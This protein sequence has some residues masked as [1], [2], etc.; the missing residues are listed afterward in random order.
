ATRLPLSGRGRWVPGLPAGEAAAESNEEGR[1]RRRRPHLEEGALIGRALAEVAVPRADEDVHRAAARLGGRSLADDERDAGRR[2]V[3]HLE[4]EREGA[5]VVLE[6]HRGAVAQA[7][8]GRLV[9]M[10]D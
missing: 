2:V 9:R 4:R 5:A 7:A 8:A 1:L 6:T 3:A 10:E